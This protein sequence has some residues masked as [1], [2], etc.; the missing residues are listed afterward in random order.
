MEGY[1]PCLCGLVLRNL[2]AE[3]LVHAWVYIFPLR[4]LMW[5]KICCAV[6]RAVWCLLESHIYRLFNHIL[7]NIEMTIN[8]DDNE[9]LPE[10]TIKTI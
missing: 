5:S 2:D 6:A 1:F 10:N 7:S 4:S 3:A 8:N 9:L